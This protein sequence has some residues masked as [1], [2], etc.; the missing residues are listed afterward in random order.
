MLVA[1]WPEPQ[2][3]NAAVLVAISKKLAARLT[4]RR[5][6]VEFIC[7]LSWNRANPALYAERRDDISIRAGRLPSQY[8]ERMK[9]RYGDSSTMP[10][11]RAIALAS[12]RLEAPSLRSSDATCVR[13]V[14]TDRH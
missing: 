9:S 11:R 6:G 14:W 12:P 8:A 5:K 3:A 13:T 2:A 7:P 4:S 1:P 10:R